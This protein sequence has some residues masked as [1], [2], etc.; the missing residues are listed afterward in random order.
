MVPTPTCHSRYSCN[1]SRL[2]LKNKRP[3]RTTIKPSR[4]TAERLIS[5][6]EASLFSSNWGCPF[7]CTW[8][9]IM[10]HIDRD[11]KKHVY[12]WRCVDNAKASD[13][14]WQILDQDTLRV[15]LGF[16]WTPLARLPSKNQQLD[17][18][19]TV[20]ELPIVPAKYHQNGGFSMA[21]LVYSDIDLRRYFWN[22]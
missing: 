17:V 8:W 21:M 9:K 16:P 4:F 19:F 22:K 2:L 20:P 7:F 5:S 18:M 10:T 14:L 6:I 11:Q 15:L 3:K 12:I 1:C 13:C